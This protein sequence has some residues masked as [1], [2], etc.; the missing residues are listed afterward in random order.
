M[1]VL[2]CHFL[3]WH[4]SRTTQARHLDYFFTY[5]SYS[6]CITIT[7][8]FLLGLLCNQQFQQPPPFFGHQTAIKKPGAN[9]FP[10]PGLH[11]ILHCCCRLWRQQTFIIPI[12]F[13]LSTLAVY[14]HCGIP[15]SCTACSI[16]HLSAF[17]RLCPILSAARS[18]S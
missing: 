16:F 13:R 14:S 17:R 6:R 1:K 2:V 7:V 15:S 18:G 10:A 12:L 5:V 4:K 11:L 8:R 3:A 9:I